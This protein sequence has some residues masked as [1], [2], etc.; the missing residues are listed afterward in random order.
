MTGETATEAFQQ[1]CDGH[2]AELEAHRDAF[3]AVSLT[4]G[5]VAASAD[6]EHFQAQLKGLDPQKRSALFLAH[7]A[8]LLEAGGGRVEP[9]RADALGKCRRL[10]R[11]FATYCAG[12]KEALKEQTEEGKGLSELHG[13]VEGASDVHLLGVAYRNKARVPGALLNVCPWCRESLCW[14]PTVVEDHATEGA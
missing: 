10:G 5:I 14:W 12:M 9:T 8:T 4:D 2:M 7:T 11:R 1:W 6:Q 13:F 3:I